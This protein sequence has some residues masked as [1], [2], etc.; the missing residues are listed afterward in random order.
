MLLVM[1][2][3]SPMSHSHYFCWCIPLLMGLLALRPP[4]SSAWLGWMV[5]GAVLGVATSLPHLPKTGSLRELGS[6]TF[7]GVVLWC[8][9]AAVLAWE[10][11]KRLPTNRAPMIKQLAA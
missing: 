2:F 9:A 3:S 4:R 5:L 6:V 8:L 7:A 10:S 1:L 11:R